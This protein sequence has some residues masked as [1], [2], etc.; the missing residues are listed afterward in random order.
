[1]DI[2]VNTLVSDLAN[3]LVNVPV[4]SLVNTIVNNHC[5][6]L[7]AALPPLNLLIT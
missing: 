6:H 4:N 7:P 2:L 3:T 5:E 1:M